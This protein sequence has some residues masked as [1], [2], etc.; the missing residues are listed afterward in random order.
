MGFDNVLQDIPV[1]EYRQR[2]A[3]TR[4]EMEKKGYEAL[5]VYSDSW[6]FGNA[7]WLSNFRPFEGI[8]GYP[9]IVF[10]PLHGDPVLLVDATNV[11]VASDE[12][13]F[14]DTRGIRQELGSIIAEFTSKHPGCKIGLCGARFFALEF[15]EI[16]VSH[17]QANATLEKTDIVEQLKSVKSEREIRN[18]IIAG[19]LADVGYETIHQM[20]EEREG[21][22]ERELARAAYAEM[23]ARG[24]D[25][26]AFDIMVQSGENATKF[27]LARP[28]DRRVMKG[29]ILLIDIGIRY[30][31]YSS[32]MARGVG[33]GPMTDEQRE[34][35][36]TCLAAWTAGVERLRPGMT[37]IEADKA[38]KELLAQT[39]FRHIAGASWGCAHALGM[40]P[41]EEVPI[42]G[43]NSRDILKEN[44]AIAFEITLAVPGIGG[45][46]IEDTIILRKDG[47]ESLTN[48]PR[49]CSWG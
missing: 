6:R 26:S 5:L 46:R 33:Y 40:E 11:D 3:L 28:R 23:F 39:R 18:M 29:D 4:A 20:L 27:F 45:T 12:T 35:L 37:A 43:P 21:W 10:L 44:Q 8:T 41:E 9:A 48:F 47:P 16:V 25:N 38:S 1:E 24:A 7:R 49:S 14:D 19:Q 30:N 36:D 2:V 15:Y 22:T 13:W 34:L 31:Y 42:I 32:D 17:L